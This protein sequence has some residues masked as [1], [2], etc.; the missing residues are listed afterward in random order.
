MLYLTEVKPIS[1][2]NAS[3]AEGIA[4]SWAFPSVA[5][6]SLTRLRSSV[7]RLSNIPEKE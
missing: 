5:L 3:A 2:L 4:T 7:F 1:C 6:R